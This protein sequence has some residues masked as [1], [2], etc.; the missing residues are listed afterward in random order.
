MTSRLKNVKVSMKKSSIGGS[1]SSAQSSA[2][3]S[4]DDDGETS[5]D[6]ETAKE[7]FEALKYVMVNKQNQLEIE[8][9]LRNCREYRKKLLKIT[10]TDLLESFPY[11]FVDPKL[12]TYAVL[13]Y[14]H[15]S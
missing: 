1:N 10:E 9:K 8:T 6:D 4:S 5:L 11:F 12:V 2:V 7:C 15:K 14:L 13:R 3:E